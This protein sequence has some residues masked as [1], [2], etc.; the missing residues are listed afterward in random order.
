MPKKPVTEADDEADAASVVDEAEVADENNVLD[1]SW[2]WSLLWYE[3][4]AAIE[5]DVA[6]TSPAVAAAAV[7]FA[8]CGNLFCCRIDVRVFVVPVVAAARDISRRRWW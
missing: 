5:T 7:A 4:N 2:T 3:A 8:V 1:G 6:V